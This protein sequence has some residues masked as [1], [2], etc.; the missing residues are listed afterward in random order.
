MG[1]DDEVCPHRE[2]GHARQLTCLFG[3]VT[4]VRC[5]WRNRG[6]ADVHPADARLSLPHGRHSPGI[7]RLAAREAVRGSFT[8]AVE[9]LTDRCGRVLG[10]RRTASCDVRSHA[11]R[12]VSRASAPPRGRVHLG[13]TRRRDHTHGWRTQR[14]CYALR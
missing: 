10:K 5:A 8:Q 1:A 4:V 9:A 12:L 6:H 3:K 2:T 7:K 13:R 11:A 14:L